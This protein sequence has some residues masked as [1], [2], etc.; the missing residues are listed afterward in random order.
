MKIETIIINRLR[1]T[2]KVH[3]SGWG[4]FYLKEQSVRWNH[5]TNTAFPAGKYLQFSPN[6]SAERDTL[7]PEVMKSLGASMEVAEQWVVRKLK[8]WQ[9]ELDEGLVLRLS[10]LGSFP[11]QNRF[12][13]E[14]GTFDAQSFGF[15]PVMIHK[16]EEPSALQSK[17][18]AS[19]KIA[20]ESKQSTL[21]A[22]QRTGAAAAVATL[23]GLG[24]MQ[25]SVATQVAGWFTSD[26]V[27]EIEALPT[28][29][30][31]TELPVATPAQPTV[32]PVV[33][34]TVNVSSNVVSEVH[35]N[36]YSV[37]VGSFREKSNADNYA[38]ELAAKGFE[39]NLVPGSLRK[40]GIGHYENRT[41]AIQVLSKLK[42]SVNSG[43]WIYAY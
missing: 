13:P 22:W 41:E 17:V 2:G 21:K 29:E 6:P 30:P 37:I 38:A 39:V 9:N 7:L 28:N 11:S 18:V 14:P 24:V 33:E 27:L 10:G 12:Q 43:A 42:T 19:L 31:A 23:F 1:S 3:L 32:E 15:V 8:G 40:V 36:G 16:L 25:S 26:D 5:I 35:S 34:T 20:S 4:T